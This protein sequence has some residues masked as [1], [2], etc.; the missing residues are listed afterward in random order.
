MEVWRLINLGGR[1][2]YFIQTV[3]E[4]AARYVGSGK[5]PPTLILV[6]P[7]EPYVCVGVHQLPDIEVDMDF[8]RFKGIPVIRRQVGGGAVYLD[9]NQ[10]FYHVVVPREHKLAKVGLNE[11]FR[12]LLKPVVCFYRSYGLNATYKPVN[13]VVIN[14]RKASGNGAALL[15]NSMVLI[16][17][18]ILDFDYEIASRVLRVP[19]D[20]LRA[21][22]VK[23]MA[24]WVTSLRR[25]LNYI[26][27]RD[28][29]ISKL[30]NCFK[31]EL[32]VEFEE[33]VLSDEEFDEVRRLSSIFK[34]KE[35][36]YAVSYGREDIALRYDP[37][38]RLVK[39]REGHYILYHEFRAEKSVKVII[40]VIDR[41]VNTLVVSGDFFINPPEALMRINDLVKGL[42]VDEVLKSSEAVV[43]EV[44]KEVKEAAGLT[45]ESLG[46][47]LIN[48]LKL[49][50]DR[51]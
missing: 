24:E 25:E 6:Y 43:N 51:I 1:D 18:V 5:Q 10:Q 27:P 26:P 15:H 12:E 46:Q 39:V 7:S 4:A 16:G 20:K 23:S 50:M 45:A 44:F 9:S 34:S 8:C 14:G 35:W 19:D 33:S 41:R 11:F 32:G 42:E 37:Q 30:V 28:E 48:S 47:A 21:H 40:E 17:N 22:L 31:A 36:L 49:L 38:S 3:Y 13:D 29:V 2:G